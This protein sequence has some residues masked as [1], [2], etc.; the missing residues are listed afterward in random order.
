[1]LYGI[2]LSKRFK[3]YYVGEFLGDAHSLAVSKRGAMKFWTRKGAQEY[4][5]AQKGVGAWRDAKP[6]YL[7]PLF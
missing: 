7:W 5:D 3:E 1:M 6:E 4:I 2:R